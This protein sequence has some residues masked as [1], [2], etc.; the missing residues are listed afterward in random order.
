VK[1][2]MLFLFLSSFVYGNVVTTSIAVADDWNRDKEEI[3]TIGFGL[4]DPN[5][6]N[7]LPAEKP[8][9]RLNGDPAMGRGVNDALIPDRVTIREGGAVNFVIGGGHVLAIYDDGTKPEE[10]NT[11]NIETNPGCPAN[12]PAQAGGVLSDS[13]KRIYR[14][15]CFSTAF[16]VVANGD[17]R[18][19]RRDGVEVVQFSKPGTYLVICARKNHFIDQ[20][21]G[22]FQMFGYVKVLPERKKS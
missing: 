11:I 5:D 3:A 22:E 6:P 16:G 19:T 12:N 10:I 14:G 18:I 17:T 15:P 21:T 4:W 7:L 2:L 13:N 8:L 1:R 20:A 9:D